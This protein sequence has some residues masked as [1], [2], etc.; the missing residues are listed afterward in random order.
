MKINS[1]RID[2][3]TNETV[4]QKELC[5]YEL[6]FQTAYTLPYSCVFFLCTCVMHLYWKILLNLDDLLV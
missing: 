2:L 4:E 3:P 6:Q 1:C 5:A